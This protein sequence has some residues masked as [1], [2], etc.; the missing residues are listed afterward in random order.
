MPNKTIKIASWNV[1][2]RLSNLSSKGR[3]N[4]T[5]IIKNIEVINADIMVILE[6]HT[7]E[8]VD[9]LTTKQKLIDLGYQIHSV[10]YDDDLVSRTDCYTNRLS[11]MFLS[12]YPIDEF[13]V[14]KLGKLRKCMVVAI[15]IGDDQNIKVIGIHLD[16]RLEETRLRQIADL[17]E[18]INKSELPTIVMGDFNAMHGEDLWPARFLKTNFSNLLSKIII[19]SFFKRVIGMAQGTT[20]KKL[21]V[22]TGLTDIDSNHQPTT[23]PK[24]LGFEYMPS[25]RLIQIDHI[26]ASKNITASN[27]SISADG[28]SDHRAISTEIS[29]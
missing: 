20:L 2:G 23:T 17:S 10:D 25:I 5:Q 16:D 11:M 7:E 1:E 12:K 18:E 13:K 8:N 27:F 14:I 15:K 9:K 22:D 21:E 3:G 6:A 26:Y 4:A 29:I 24:I 28:G 19:P